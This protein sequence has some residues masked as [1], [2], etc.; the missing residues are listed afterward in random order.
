M[1]RYPHQVMKRPAQQKVGL[2]MT[3]VSGD[4]EMPVLGPR[5]IVATRLDHPP[6]RW[7]TPQPALSTAPANNSYLCS[8]LSIFTQLSQPTMRWPDPVSWEREGEDIECSEDEEWSEVASLSHG[9]G[10]YWCGECG[11][12]ELVEECQRFLRWVSINPVWFIEE[13]APTFQENII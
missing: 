5:Y 9:S 7:T 8:K 6:T 1:A 12:G 13:L 11:Q 4:P 2:P 10:H 3:T